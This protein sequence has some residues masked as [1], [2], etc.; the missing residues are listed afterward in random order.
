MSNENTTVWQSMVDLEERTVC[1]QKELVSAY[2]RLGGKQVGE[3]LNL[4]TSNVGGDS[5]MEELFSHQ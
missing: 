1:G 4:V 3:V 5:R 2:T